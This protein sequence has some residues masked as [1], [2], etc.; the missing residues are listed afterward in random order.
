MS[1]SCNFAALNFLPGGSLHRAIHAGARLVFWK[2]GSGSDQLT[3]PWKSSR[4]NKDSVFGE[5][6]WSKDCRSYQGESSKDI[7]GQHGCGAV[8]FSSVF[9]QQNGRVFGMDIYIHIYIYRELESATIRLPIN[10][11]VSWWWN[12]KDLHILSQKI[13]AMKRPWLFRLYRGLY[14][15]VL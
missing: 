10:Q 8:L 11:R 5:N 3:R 15:P 14:Y 1:K 9:G 2:L 4:P 7:V 13:W 12:S 6:P